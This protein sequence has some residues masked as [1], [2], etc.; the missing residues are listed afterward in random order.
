[1][2]VTISFPL[3]AQHGYVLLKVGMGLDLSLLRT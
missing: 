1:M 2:I 3:Y